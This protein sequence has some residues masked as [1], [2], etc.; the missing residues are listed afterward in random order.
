MRIAIWLLA[1][2]TLTAACGSDAPPTTANSVA[3]A[4]V[5]A[6]ATPAPTAVAPPPAPPPPPPP[7]A[8]P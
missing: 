5:E 3:T 1:A 8:A 2:I 6:P 7:G 4:P